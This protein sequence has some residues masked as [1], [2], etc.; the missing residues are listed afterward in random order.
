MAGWENGGEH[1][2][3][4]KMGE[5]IE[6]TTSDNGGIWDTFFANNSGARE[7]KLYLAGATYEQDI[8]G[9]QAWY[10]RQS[11]IINTLYIEANA[12][13]F[14]SE[15]FGVN[16]V[17]QYMKEKAIGKLKSYSETAGNEISKID[18]N[19]YCSGK[20]SVFMDTFFI[21]IL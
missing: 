13:P 2:K 19:I 3:L 21:Y 8:F 4:A 5:V 12:K 14:D 7:S 20:V 11:E 16:L 15:I 1:T 18:G 10:G 17:G 9:I 6:S